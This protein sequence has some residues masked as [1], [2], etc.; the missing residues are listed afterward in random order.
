MR[1]AFAELSKLGIK[2]VIQGD[3]MYTA[4]DLQTEEI[5]GEQCYTFGPQHNYICSQLTANWASALAQV[6]WA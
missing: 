6:R 4:E 5:D 2:N 1:I 3:L